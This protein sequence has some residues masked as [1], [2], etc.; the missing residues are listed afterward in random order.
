MQHISRTCANGVGV[1]IPIG[2]K[3]TGRQDEVI[4]C[5]PNLGGLLFL[6]PRVRRGARWSPY[7]KSERIYLNSQLYRRQATSIARRAGWPV[8]DIFG[9]ARD[10]LRN[11]EKMDMDR[12]AILTKKRKNRP[13]PSRAHFETTLPTL[14][15]AQNAVVLPENMAS[16]EFRTIAEKA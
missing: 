3:L 13:M 8:S 7:E 2:K 12:R 16:S 10:W 14:T 1:H 9:D 4:T 11:I 5:V 15:N 6:A